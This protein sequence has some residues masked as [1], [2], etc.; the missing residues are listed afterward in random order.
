MWCVVC[1]VWVLIQL[2]LP[3]R[4]AP[5]PPPPPRRPVLPSPEPAMH[6]RTA[7]TCS[8]H[9]AVS[10]TDCIFRITVKKYIELVYIVYIY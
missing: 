1:G 2:Q 5:P 9:P 10:P 8:S 6:P 7:S 4:L 3:A